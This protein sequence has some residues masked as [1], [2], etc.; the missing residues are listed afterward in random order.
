VATSNAVRRRNAINC[1]KIIIA[2]FD[3]TAHGSTKGTAACQVEV[4]HVRSLSAN[5]GNQRSI[6]RPQDTA[7]R[8]SVVLKSHDT[9]CTEFKLN[10]LFIVVVEGCATIHVR[11]VKLIALVCHLA[12]VTAV[13]DSEKVKKFSWS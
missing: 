13:V 12:E 4:T 10:V 11:L 1:F 2:V 9:S 8:C 6:L 5:V 7:I 3:E